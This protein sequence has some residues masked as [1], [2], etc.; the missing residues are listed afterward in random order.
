MKSSYSLATIALFT[1]STSAFVPSRQTFSSSS[2]VS[3]AGFG[4][5]SSGGGGGMSKKKNGKTSKP[6]KNNN[7]PIFK[8]KSQWD[9]YISLKKATSVRVA[10]RVAND[11]QDVGEWFEIGSVKSEGDEFTE[12]A[13]AF[14]RGI[15]AEHAKRLHPLQVSFINI[16][17]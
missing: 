9:R 4:A 2:P 11:G 12:A 1:S 8:P 17:F 16:L 15:I 6:T 3:M 5:A 7:S 14:Q 10:A 13:V